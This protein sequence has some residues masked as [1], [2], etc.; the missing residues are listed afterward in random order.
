MRVET[1]ASGTLAILAAV[2][3]LVGCRPDVRSADT[4]GTNGTNGTETGIE[5]DAKDATAEAG[6]PDSGS[7]DTRTD[8]TGTDDEGDASDA[9]SDAT[10]DDTSQP[11]DGA[12]AN[13]GTD[14]DDGAS[15][16]GGGE[17]A[18]DHDKVG[19]T[20]ELEAKGDYQVSGTAE[21]VDNCTVVIE[22]FTYSG[23]GIVVQIY[24]APTADDFSSGF[25]MSEDLKGQSFDNETLEVSLPPGKSL[26]DLGAISVWCVDADVDFGSGEFTAP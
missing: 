18:A 12:D 23:D 5:G 2:L 14:A 11:A 10:S 7:S 22:N 6:P 16:D 3:L 13:T 19:W 17:C 8:D 15:D 25:P 21:I 26:D 24:G 1:A 9:T 20:A 4:G